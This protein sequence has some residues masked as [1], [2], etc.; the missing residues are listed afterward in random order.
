MIKLIKDWPPHGDAGDTISAGSYEGYLIKSGIAEAVAVTNDEGNVTND[1][2]NVT[3][4]TQSGT[5]L[6]H[7]PIDAY[8]LKG[9]ELKAYAEAQL[10]EWISPEELAHKLHKPDLKEKCLALG[11]SQSGHKKDLAERIYQKLQEIL[12]INN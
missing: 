6:P 11:I 12:I 1:E 7:I 10:N 9:E 5:T 2:G 8:E 3:K 4:S